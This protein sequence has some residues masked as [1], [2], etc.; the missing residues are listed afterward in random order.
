MKTFCSV[1]DAALIGLI[2]SAKKRIVFVAPGLTLAV[3][4]VLGHR[5]HELDGALDITVVL[6]ADED[7]CRIGYGEVAALQELHKLA[8]EHGFWLKSQP[9]LR[10]GVLLADEQTLVW[11]PTPCSV[12][13]PPASQ[14]WPKGGQ[15][16]LLDE[17]APL[18]PNGLLLGSNP[19]AQLARAIA[20]EGT[21]T[22]PGDAEI[23]QSAIT[24]EQVMETVEAHIKN[25]PIP[26]DLARVTRVFSSK[27]QFVEL[28]VQRARLS[29]SQ[30][31]VSNR[32]LNA[33]VKGELEGLI[34]SKLHAFAELRDEEIA[35]QAFVNGVA[36]MDSH[37]KP[38]QEKVSEASLERQRHDLEKR[39]VTDIPGFGKLIEKDQKAEFQ[40]RLDA[41]KV[42]LLEHSKGVRAL[43]D[44]QSEQ[45][46]DEAID[47]IMARSQRAPSADGKSVAPLNADAIRDELQQG[48]DRAKGGEPSLSLVF[49]DIT[50]EQTQSA[51]FRKKL[52][53]SLSASARK[54]IGKWTEA[55]D[56]AR[57]AGRPSAIKA[58]P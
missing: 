36:A 40:L 30:L 38:L 52:D 46:L 43:L 19:G 27:L 37:G 35:V 22:G 26:V 45:I 28:K 49:K 42:Q 56:A 58:A 14:P 16:G 25:P 53:H 8:Q 41:Y 31:S 50:Y 34:E 18:A 1:D 4:K 20:A 48:L 47:L 44:K 15:V 32:L 57:E 55:F 33:D 7:V 17:P 24:P 9:G 13:A 5:F 6:D 39:F 12:E 10:V 23:G 29:H 2:A 21:A 11:S 51:D 54:R 3:A